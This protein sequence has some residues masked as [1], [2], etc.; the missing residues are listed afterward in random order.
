MIILV[1]VMAISYEETEF[2]LKSYKEVKPSM[3]NRVNFIRVPRS[4]SSWF[5]GFGWEGSRIVAVDRI[6]IP[7]GS[8][9]TRLI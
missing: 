5:W 4:F 9:F 8:E 6:A 3:E 1:E 7:L 2:G